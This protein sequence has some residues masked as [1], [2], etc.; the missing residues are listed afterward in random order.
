MIFLFTQLSLSRNNNQ[1]FYRE[2]D[3][4]LDSNWI[5]SEIFRLP[6]DY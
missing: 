3:K 1:L 6:N 5:E 4:I 2:D